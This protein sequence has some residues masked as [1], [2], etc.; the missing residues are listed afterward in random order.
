MA[1]QKFSLGL[2]FG[3]FDHQRTGNRPAH[4]RRVKATI[5]QPLSNIFHHQTRALNWK[6]ESEFASLLS[7]KARWLR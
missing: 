1:S 5:D 6:A 3:R 4:R 2:G 7:L